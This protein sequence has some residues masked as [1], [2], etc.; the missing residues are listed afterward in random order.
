MESSNKGNNYNYIEYQLFQII[1]ALYSIDIYLIKCYIAYLYLLSNKSQ[2]F[3]VLV[4]YL[5]IKESK[6]K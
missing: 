3:L 6:K 1:K 2:T 4:S 5:N